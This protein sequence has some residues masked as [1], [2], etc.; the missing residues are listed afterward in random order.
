MKIQLILILC[1]FENILSK[2]HKSMRIPARARRRFKGISKAFSNV[3]GNFNPNLNL[4]T[5]HR[6]LK[7]E[8][9]I[10]KK[11][12]KTKK[13]HKDKKLKHKKKFSKGKERN[14][15]Q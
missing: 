12:N 2:T 1:I 6:K 11:S 9:Q 4:Q 7:Q 3:F 13:K 5:I 8:K 14:L 15:L 10:K